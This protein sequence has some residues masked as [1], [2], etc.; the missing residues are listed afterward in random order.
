MLI[1]ITNRCRMGCRHCCIEGSS[2]DGAHMSANVFSDCLKFIRRIGDPIVMISGGEPFEHPRVFSFAAQAHREGFKVL[3]LSNG[4]FSS[5]PEMLKRIERSAFTIQV[6]S[7]PR[8]YPK[9]IDVEALKGL[10]QVKVERNIRSIFPCA[11]TVKNQIVASR[12]SP[13]CFN[14]RSAVR[15]LKDLRLA[16][17]ELMLHG[18]FCT[19]S[20]NIDGSIRLGEAD[21]CHRIGNVKDSPNKILC[22]I[23]DA[24][25]GRCG[26]ADNLS[27]RQREALGGVI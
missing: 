10:P 13:A 20:V 24:R 11:R 15:K 2:C 23:L 7:D 25:C 16:R 4:M 8:Y 26:M 12:L 27:D 21:T 9:E 22:G 1:R 3:L 14:L 18:F 6:T 5:D 17:T 19:P